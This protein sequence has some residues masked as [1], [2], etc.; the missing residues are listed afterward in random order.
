MEHGQEGTVS[1]SPI[2]DLDLA[3]S[4]YEITFDGGARSTAGRAKV[5]GAGATPWHHPTTGGPPIRIA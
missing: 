2:P 3:Q 1:D 4:P 5:A